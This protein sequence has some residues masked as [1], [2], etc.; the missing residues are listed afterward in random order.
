ML[1]EIIT[2][3]EREKTRTVWCTFGYPLDIVNSSRVLS[4]LHYLKSG[5]SFNDMLIYEVGSDRAYPL[6]TVYDDVVERLKE[7]DE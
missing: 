4:F 5:N 1:Y 3:N 7:V 2:L 6:H